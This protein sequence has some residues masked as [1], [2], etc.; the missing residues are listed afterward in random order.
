MHTITTTIC[1]YNN[2]NLY[3]FEIPKFYDIS[4]NHDINLLVSILLSKKTKKRKIL[5][6]SMLGSNNFA[7]LTE[8]NT[9]ITFNVTKHYF[10]TLFLF[11]YVTVPSKESI[12]FSAQLECILNAFL[13]PPK[14]FGLTEILLGTSAHGG[15][16]FNNRF[17]KWR[18][19]SQFNITNYSKLPVLLV[20]HF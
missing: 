15:D 11:R 9:N 4:I 7:L 20:T 6:H 19:L 2:Q 8:H 17:S 18:E 3:R 1:D 10:V 16:R 12:A 5:T 14:R 13:S